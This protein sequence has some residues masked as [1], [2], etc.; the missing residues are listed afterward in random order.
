MSRSCVLRSFLGSVYKS[1]G[2]FSQASFQWI[3]KWSA[4]CWC[5]VV[6]WAGRRVLSQPGTPSSL[7]QVMLMDVFSHSTFSKQTFPETRD[8]TKKWV[9][10][11]RWHLSSSKLPKHLPSSFLDS[12]LKKSL[13]FAYWKMNWPSGCEALEMQNVLNVLDW[14]TASKSMPHTPAL[15][16]QRIGETSLESSY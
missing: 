16:Q 5:S 2:D 8:R 13:A 3:H 11:M 14:G 7:S 1:L 15:A 9:K 6:T 4:T 10:S 12:H